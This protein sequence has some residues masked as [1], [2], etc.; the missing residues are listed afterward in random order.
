MVA[1]S[2][3]EMDPSHLGDRIQRLD[4]RDVP[5]LVEL[6]SQTKPGPFDV[7]TSRLGDFWGIKERGILAAMAGERLKHT[8][9]TE[10]SGV[11]V[12]PDYRGRGYARALS[13][14]VA[15]QICSRGETPYLH[16]YSTNTAAIQLYE[17]PA[18]TQ[19]RP[20]VAT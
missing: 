14:A 4:E 10:V 19:K 6:A 9:Y 11:C 17:S 1:E 3:I 7:G 13:T 16:A 2:K 12:H 5:S 8:G 20:V 15:S 18:A